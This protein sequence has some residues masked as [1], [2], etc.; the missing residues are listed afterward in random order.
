MRRRRVQKQ[1]QEPSP[2][3]THSLIGSAEMWEPGQL[4]RDSR[5]QPL[6]EPIP[7][8][9]RVQRPT[10][11]VI[12][13]EILVEIIVQVLTR[14]RVIHKRLGHVNSMFSFLLSSYRFHKIGC[15]KVLCT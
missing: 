6:S 2:L 7:I 1:S 4:K 3:W 9:F 13:V 12:K 15:C 5:L 8:T 14:N 11:D 10:R